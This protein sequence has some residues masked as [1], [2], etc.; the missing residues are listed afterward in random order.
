MRSSARRSLLPIACS[1]LFASPAPGLAAEA[2]SQSPPSQQ[3][4][5]PAAQGQG[6]P[7]AEAKAAVPN[8][9]HES[10]LVSD[11][12]NTLGAA[13]DGWER[14]T[15]MDFT[16]SVRYPLAYES[17]TEGRTTTTGL[18]LPYV[19]FTGRMSQYFDRKSSPVVTKRFNPKLM[20][21]VYESEP[22][23]GKK[24]WLD[25]NALDFYDFG[26]AHES[27]GQ[28]VNTPEAFNAVANNFNSPQVAQDYINRGWDYLDYLKHFHFRQDNRASADVEFK[29]FL[30]HG[31]AQSHIMETYPWETPRAVTHI[32]QVDGIRLAGGFALGADW[33]RDAKITW[34][35][36]Y[37]DLAKYN[38]LRVES[39]FVPLSSYLGVPV[40]VWLQSGYDNSVAEFYVHSWFAGMAFS[41]ETE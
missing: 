5:A 31:L 40:I 24:L 23:Q 26:Y 25:D 32:G 20:V 22:P 37:R 1:L 38:T 15:Y 29:Y 11:E 8:E 36:G 27:N 19:S 4:T 18:W 41:F 21:R 16:V 30:N 33:F 34:I 2:D 28:Y 12:P 13:E 39:T 35:T 3:Q 10:R 7:A 17:R 14:H 6:L 9:Q